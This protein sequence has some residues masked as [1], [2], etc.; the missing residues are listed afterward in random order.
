[1]W[2]QC[3]F[4]LWLQQSSWT[5]CF[6]SSEGSSSVEKLQPE[7]RQPQMDTS[8]SRRGL[9]QTS[10][11]VSSKRLLALCVCVSVVFYWVLEK[12]VCTLEKQLGGVARSCSGET[13]SQPLPRVPRGT[14]TRTKWVSHWGR[15]WV[16]GW[17]SEIH[18]GHFERLPAEACLMTTSEC[19]DAFLS[20]PFCFFLKRP[21]QELSVIPLQA[22]AF[23]WQKTHKLHIQVWTAFPW[24][25]GKVATMSEQFK[26]SICFNT[27]RA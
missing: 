1:M 14:L 7:R 3:D 13:P 10:A 12:C 22:T 20:F 24:Q 27:S 25:L 23:A 11:H 6:D 26:T 17:V 18:L 8:C 4:R 5:G 19:G 16:G 2:S 9:A 21:V 15:E